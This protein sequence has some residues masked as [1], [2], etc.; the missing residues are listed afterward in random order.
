MVQMVYPN[1][2]NAARYVW[3]VAA[4]SSDALFGVQ[5]GP[6]NLP[7][8]DF[9]VTDGRMPAHG[10]IA[11]RTQTAIV[12]GHFDYN[13]RYAPALVA[14][15][16]AAARAQ[17]N[18]IHAPRAEETP[19]PAALDE[20]TGKYLISSGNSVDVRRDGARLVASS[21]SDSGELLPQGRDNFY[22][23]AFDVWIAFRRN[24][25]GEVTG[26]TSAGGGDFEAQRQR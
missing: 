19:S 6:Y 17:A 12:S 14:A 18:Q 7:E 21:G 10:Q 26:L 1:P 5:V 13:W 16:D 20:F 24:A 11:T 15:G 25:A 9:V 2:A 4:N 23:P 8:W 22:L 3:V